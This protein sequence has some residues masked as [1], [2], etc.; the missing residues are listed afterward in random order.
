[1]T[2]FSTTVGDLKAALGAV[3]PHTD[4]DDTM[5]VTGAIYVEV[6]KDS[7]R[8]TG[9]NRYTLVRVKLPLDVDRQDGLTEGAFGFAGK[10]TKQIVATL[11]KGKRND[12]LPI[13]V[14]VNEKGTMVTFKG[15]EA[16]ISVTVVLQG[17][18]DNYPKVD[19]VIP[20]RLYE[21][22]GKPGVTAVTLDP[23]FLTLFGKSAKALYG[24]TKANTSL[25]FVFADRKDGAYS[26]EPAHRPVGVMFGYVPDGW[27]VE[28][29]IMPIRD[30]S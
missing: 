2:K 7:V 21:T 10:D 3:A 11:L 5:P 29:I 4:P 22:D 30:G 23:D 24:S 13:D 19:A 26:A 27:G 1:M 25:R 16:Q 14:S 9:T 6:S 12:Q 17:E 18:K 8:F 20:D 28:G 15:L